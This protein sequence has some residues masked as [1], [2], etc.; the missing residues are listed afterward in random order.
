MKGLNIGKKVRKGRRK[1][2]AQLTEKKTLENRNR[3]E[4]RKS[5][6]VKIKRRERF[7]KV[8]EQDRV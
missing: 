8:T 1:K 5:G 4:T 2:S 6:K 3:R 7:R